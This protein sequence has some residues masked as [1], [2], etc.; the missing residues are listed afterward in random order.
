MTSL[1]LIALSLCDMLTI[2]ER[3]ERRAS[4]RIGWFIS[5]RRYE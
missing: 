1:V 2:V 4:Q 3:W 5:P